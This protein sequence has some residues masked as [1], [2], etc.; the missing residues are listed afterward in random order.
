MDNEIIEG[1]RKAI[2]EYGVQGI[3]IGTLL[4]DYQRLNI[5]TLASKYNLIVFSP[6]WRK[7]QEEY[8]RE[9]IR[10][11]FKIIITSISTYG[12]PPSLIGKVLS[13][14]DVNLIISLARRYGFNP[15]FEGG[16]AETLVID[17][18]LFKYKLE[19]EGYVKKVDE[20]NWK[21][22]V[23]RIQLKEKS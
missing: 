11:G 19:V 13:M 12:L 7:N 5:C 14:E 8:M 20:Y 23:T 18:P 9:L 4:S 22:V 1:L 6:L 10:L 2:K 15:A 16:E 21:Y 3:V 17:A